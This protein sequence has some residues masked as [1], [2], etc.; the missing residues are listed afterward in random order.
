MTDS[1]LLDDMTRKYADFLNGERGKSLDPSNVPARL[2]AYVPLAE[3]WGVT[4]DLDRE[5]LVERAPE[6]AKQDLAAAIER[7][8]DDLDDWL[9]GPQADDPAPTAEYLA[10]SAMRM[11]ADFL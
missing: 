11:A 3:L 7:V 8:D 5:Q 4:D 6:A 10:F 2:R 1:E 9:A